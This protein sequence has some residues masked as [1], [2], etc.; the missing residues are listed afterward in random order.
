MPFRKDNGYHMLPRQ[1]RLQCLHYVHLR[2]ME[3]KMWRKLISGVEMERLFGTAFRL[4]L[5]GWHL[6]LVFTHKRLAVK[7]TMVRSTLVQWVLK[8]TFLQGKAKKTRKFAAV[9][10]MLSP[11]DIRLYDF[12]V[13]ANPPRSSIL[14]LEKKTRLN[15]KRKKKKSRLKLFAE[16]ELAVSRFLISVSDGRP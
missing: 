6:P 12:L 5:R 14:S 4:A 13:L 10:R 16:C 7:Y 11:K 8:L 1:Q 15:Y 2:M 3:R 9:K